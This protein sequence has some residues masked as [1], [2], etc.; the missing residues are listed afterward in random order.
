[1]QRLLAEVWRDTRKTVVYVTHNVAE[2]VYLADRVV[3]MTPHPGTVKIEVPIGLTRPR[4]PLSLD[5]IEHQK[6]L[7]RHLGERAAP[8]GESKS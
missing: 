2:A 1:M 8:E 6:E 7:L 5:F 4:D 3:V